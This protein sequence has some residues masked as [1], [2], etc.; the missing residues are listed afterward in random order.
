VTNLTYLWDDDVCFGFSASSL[1]HQ[2][3]W[4]YIAKLIIS[5]VNRQMFTLV[6]QYYMSSWETTNTKII[7]FVLTRLGFEPTTYRSRDGI[8][9]IWHHRSNLKHVIQVTTQ[10]WKQTMNVNNSI[11]MNTWITLNT[12]EDNDILA[13]EIE[14]LDLDRH[15]NV[16]VLNQLTGYQPSP[17]DN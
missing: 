1:K 3:T 4:R 11:N 14:G 9:K 17:L 16:M 10:L 7:V 15:N 5:T 13:L 2:S 8:Y 12:K 6:A